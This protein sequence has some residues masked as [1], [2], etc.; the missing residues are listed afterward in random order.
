MGMLGSGNPYASEGF[1]DGV[2][3]GFNLVQ[4]QR[5]FELNKAKT[6]QEMSLQAQAGARAQQLFPGQLAEQTATTRS[7]NAA[8]TRAEY[9]TSPNYLALE[10][11]GKQSTIA[12]Q[13]AQATSAAAE[14][15]VH[16]EQTNFY[17]NLPQVLA[18][19]E[20][21]SD[22][23]DQY[24]PIVSDPQHKQ[25]I[26]SLY[27]ILN[28]IP[29]RSPDT[30]EIA[31]TATALLQ[32][33][34]TPK[35]PVTIDL[36][37]AMRLGINA[38][39][40]LVGNK[41]SNIHAD[42]ADPNNMYLELEH[43]YQLPDGSIYSAPRT[44]DKLHD[45]TSAPDG[46]WMKVP[47]QRLQEQL[48]GASL[49][50]RALDYVQQDKGLATPAQAAQ[51]IKGQHEAAT[52]RLKGFV[53]FKSNAGGY[54]TATGEVIGRRDM[55]RQEYMQAIL[56]ASTDPKLQDKEGTIAGL[57]ARAKSQGIDLGNDSDSSGNSPGL[58]GSPPAG[59]SGP[60]SVDWNSLPTK[61]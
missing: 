42:P 26:E 20:A 38:R 43:Q 58:S 22:G 33:V 27:G 8:A 52:L 32:D 44:E 30:P 21:V 41:V 7:Q 50:T 6:Q 16:S 25:T 34:I 47:K 3:R 55:S 13:K 59:Q 23:L 18:A 11:Q 56:K 9:E 40:Q 60:V 31:N 15:G 48:Q 17:K 51:L 2:T 4:S 39:S 46:N 10:S 35:Q 1:A 36:P 19:H 53:P 24:L 5:E 14:A 54:D 49:L 61:R 45:H 28:G 29:I 12:L 37:E 57:Y